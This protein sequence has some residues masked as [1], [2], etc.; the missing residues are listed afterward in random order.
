MLITASALQLPGASDSTWLSNNSDCIT[1]SAVT[2]PSCPHVTPPQLSQGLPPCTQLPSAL[3][4]F[5]LLNACFCASSAVTAQEE[6]RGGWLM[7]H[8]HPHG[9]CCLQNAV[10]V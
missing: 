9:V 7:H 5:A 2:A 8:S 3:T 10:S 4:L 6:E 1:H